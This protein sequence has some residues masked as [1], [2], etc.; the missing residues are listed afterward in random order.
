M[1]CPRTAR[2]PVEEVIAALWCDL[3]QVDAVGVHDSFFDLGGHS[4]LATRAVSRIRQI[5]GVELG[6]RALLA[7]PTVAALAA[8]V[9]AARPAGAAPPVGRIDRH[10]RDGDLPLSFAQRRLWLV[11]RLAPE[12]PAYNMPLAL[13]LE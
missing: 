1:W 7:A 11:H 8:A 13:R 2:S 5:F 3:L 10:R 9:E 12:S 4:L 6:L